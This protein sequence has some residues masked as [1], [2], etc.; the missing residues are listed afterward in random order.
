MSKIKIG[1]SVGDINGIGLEVILKTLIDDRIT[2]MC[3]PII[4]GS[5][6]IVS[7]HKNIAKLDNFS[8]RG[9]K[10]AD[11]VFSDDVNVVNCWQENVNISLGTVNEVGG[12]YALNSLE[13]AT[14]DLKEG[15]IDALVTAPFNKKAVEMAG[16]R[17]PGHTEYLTDFFNAGESVM[18]LVN[19]DLRIGLVT[20]HLPLANVAATITKELIEK[21]IT[22]LNNALKQDFGIARPKIAVLALNPHAGDNG[23]LGSEEEEIIIP[24]VKDAKRKNII[25]MGPYSADGFFGSSQWKNF[26]AILAMYHDQG[27]IPFKALS[28][29]AGVNYTCGLPCIRTSP[30]HGTAHEIAGQNIANPSSFRKALFTAIDLVRN[31][32]DYEEMTSN[33]M[34]KQEIE[35]ERQPGN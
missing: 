21:K 24:A 16:F 32:R 30:D 26:D 17:Y 34:M 25:V 18:L 1:I 3:I 14:H 5:T 35:S 11:R 15:K 13:A 33:P 19:D 10:S 20:N 31:R 8:Y 12:K 28:F 2:K 6:K 9:I 7:Y 23:L 4:Y 27:L 29:G 22:I